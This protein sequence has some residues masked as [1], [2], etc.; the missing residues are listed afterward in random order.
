MVSIL[1][2]AA[3]VVYYSLDCG[4]KMAKDFDAASSVGKLVNLGIK[5]VNKDLK[6]TERLYQPL[7]DTLK[8]VSDCSAIRN[9]AGK[10]IT[11][12][13]G[14]A[15][16]AKPSDL[17]WITPTVSMPNVLKI[18]SVSC[19]LAADILGSL[20]W[21][22]NLELIDLAKLSS[23]I[24]N[25]PVLGKLVAGIT[26][27]SAMGTLNVVGVI[28]DLADTTRDICQNGLTFYNGAQAVGDVAKLVGIVLAT[29]SGNLLVIAI[30]ADSTATICTLSRFV[31]KSY[32]IGM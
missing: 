5:Y 21:L 20:K 26:L 15:A 19:Q 29:T 10:V 7:A 22:D 13:S 30:I 18:T 28:I 23:D 25:L 32:N 11:L 14:Q 24:G 4:G 12:I 3:N 31:M 16:G 1:T 6:S 8:V 2:A 27:Q 9:W 17:I